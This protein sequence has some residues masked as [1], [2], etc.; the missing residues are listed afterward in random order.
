[1]DGFVGGRGDLGGKRHRAPAVAVLPALRHLQYHDRGDGVGGDE[2]ARERV[3][4]I[5]LGG[6][7]GRREDEVDEVDRVSPRVHPELRRRNDAICYLLDTPGHALGARL[8]KRARV[9]SAV[10]WLDPNERRARAEL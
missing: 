8:V 4:A 9:P 6:A 2:I 10:I 1:M 3:D 7:R 5:V